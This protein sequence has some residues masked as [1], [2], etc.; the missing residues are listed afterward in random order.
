M[1]ILNERERRTKKKDLLWGEHV[2]R[3]IGAAVVVSVDNFGKYQ[4]EEL[5][6]CFIFFSSSYSAFFSSFRFL[7][8]AFQNRSLN[9]FLRR[10][11]RIEN[12][13]SHTHTQ[14]WQKVVFFD[15]QVFYIQRI[16]SFVR[17]QCYKRRRLTGFT[18]R[19]IKRS[20]T[21][22]I[23]FMFFDCLPALNDVDMISFLCTKLCQKNIQKH[24]KQRATHK[25]V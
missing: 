4:N 9:F 7:L 21:S 11:L 25:N 22:L 12:I 23:N 20:W 8:N 3:I 2:R 18:T 5:N 17:L 14:A 13:Y 15:H 6:M 16:C 19:S 24:N 1:C 10:P